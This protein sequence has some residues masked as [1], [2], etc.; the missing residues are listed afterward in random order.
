MKRVDKFLKKNGDNM[1]YIYGEFD[2]W[3]APAFVPI[4]GKTNALKVVKPGGSHITRINNLP[5]DQ[6][7]VVLDTLGKWLGVEVVSELE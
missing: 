4:P 5:D 1:I 2:P 3:S 7:K 6:K